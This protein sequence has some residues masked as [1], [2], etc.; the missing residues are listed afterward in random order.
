VQFEQL[1]TRSYL[2]AQAPNTSQVTLRIGEAAES[3]DS[4]ADAVTYMEA[5]YVPGP[6]RNTKI[7]FDFKDVTAWHAPSFEKAASTIALAQEQVVTYEP[8]VDFCC[9]P[10]IPIRP[11][12][13]SRRSSGRDLTK[14]AIIIILAVVVMGALPSPAAAHIC[15]GK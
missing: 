4:S 14:L 5:N 7:R 6:S 9:G 2:S 15:R 3:L 11:A 1:L 13:P 8:Q 12:P 10:R